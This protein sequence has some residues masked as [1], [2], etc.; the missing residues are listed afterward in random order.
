MNN[1]LWFYTLPSKPTGQQSTFWTHW[2]GSLAPTTLPGRSYAPRPLLDDLT[3][4]A[5]GR[6]SLAC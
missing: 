2:D 4:K 3:P 6:D 1:P 5:L